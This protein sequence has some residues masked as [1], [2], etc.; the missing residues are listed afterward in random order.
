MTVTP[1]TTTI[2]IGALASFPT[3]AKERLL[4]QRRVF[5][6]LDWW[7]PQEWFESEVFWG[8]GTTSIDAAILMNPMSVSPQQTELMGVSACAWLRWC[9]VADAV[10]ASSVLPQL[11]GHGREALKRLGI[12]RVYCIVEPVH[13]I[14]PYLCDA[15]F[16][17]VDDVITLVN[18]SRDGIKSESDTTIRSHIR[19]AHASDLTAV[20]RIDTAAFDEQW[21]YPLFVLE[22]ALLTCPYFTVMEF[23]GQIV[24]YL[25][26]VISDREAHIT[27]LAVHPE[28]QRLGLG[29]QLLQNAIAALRMDFDVNGISL[30]TQA[31]NTVS[32]KLYQRNGFKVLQPT[33]RVMCMSY[34]D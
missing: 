18:R 19:Q 4:T 33:L 6:R 12:R 21:R 32:Q 3:I 28:Y 24:G 31:T 11:F 2:H 16:T 34:D 26:A 17:R 9:A 30:N 27:R 10:S 14:M 5:N 20:L 23:A 25:F 29:N 22:K 15:G 7:L 13:W 1:L 8:V